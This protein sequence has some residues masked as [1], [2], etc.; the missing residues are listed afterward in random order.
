MSRRKS[1]EFQDAPAQGKLKV[2]R[3]LE[4]LDALQADETAARAQMKRDAEAERPGGFL[5]VDGLLKK[6]GKALSAPV[7]R[8]SF[9]QYSTAAAAAV[10]IEGCARRPEANIL[11]YA[12]SPE[13]LVPGVPSHFAT[14]TQRN[15]DALGIVVTSHDGR[16]TKV[17]GNPLHPSSRGASDVRAQVAVWDLYDPDR[18]HQ[19]T[20]RGDDGRT[21]KT[22]AEFDEAFGT[23]IGGLG[24]GA[25]LRVLA[26]ATNSPSMVRIRAALA[27]RF[28]AAKLYTYDSVNDDNSREGT[29]Q[30]LGQ[31]MHV[32]YELSRAR[33]V[34]SLDCDFLGLETGSVRNG[35]GF[36]PGRAITA[37][38]S[39]MSRLYVVEATH[40]ITGGSADHRLALPATRV[41]AY[42]RAL[43][44]A[45]EVPGVQAAATDGIPAEWIRAVAADLREAGRGAAVL[46]G[47]N[48]PA[49]VHALGLAINAHLGAIGST[50]LTNAVLDAE[51]P[52]SLESIRALVSEIEGANTLL[53]LGGN[54]VYDAPADVDFAAL[55][56]RDGLTSVHLAHGIDE[57]GS[58]CT[59]QVP[60]AHELETWGDLRAADGTRSIQQPLIAPLWGARSA[61]E[62]LARVAGERNWRG[63]AVVRSTFR[64]AT[65]PVSFERDW[66]AALHAGVVRGSTLT[67]ETPAID[68]SLLTA[69]LSRTAA[70][71]E[72][73]EVQFVPDAAL[74]DG[75]HAN[76]VWA[77]ELADP[78]TKIVWD[79]VALVSREFA[80]ELNVRPQDLI[81]ISKGDRSVELPVWILPGHANQSVTLTLG[82]G[83]TQAGRYAAVADHRPADKMGG[84]FRVEA[85]RDSE[86][87]Y[88]GSG[89]TVEKATG[90]Y[91]VVQT[92]THDNMEGRPIAIDA[93]LDQYK[94][95]PQFASFRTVEFVSTDPL[96]RQVNYDD[97][98]VQ[99][100][101]STLPAVLHKWGMVIDLSSCTGC[102]ACVVACQSEN[103]IPAVGK[104]EVER[105]R[106]MAWM[107]ID[108]Y[109][110]GEDSN[111]PQI[112]LQPV[113]C[114]H[115]EEAP[116]ENV[117]PVNATAHSPEGLNDMAYNRCIGTRYCANNCP[118]KVRRYNYL[119]WH[120][121][122][123][124]LIDE[125]T[126][127]SAIPGLG[128]RA[129]QD[130]ANFPEERKLAFNPN[131]TVR[132]RGVMEKC[133]YC[134]Q[135]IQGARI[136]ARR[137]QRVMRDGDIV[138][139]CQSACPT[140]AITF[141]DLNDPESRVAQLAVRDRR[142]KLLA[143][144]GT[145]PRTT[146][147]GKIRNPNPAFPAT[148][149]RDGEHA[150][151][152]GQ[153][154]HG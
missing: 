145:Q 134:V 89:F 119:D 37:P 150:A 106:E 84:G 90:H 96:W 44:A 117:C 80:N 7:S 82:Y 81:R 143:E 21:A 73:I 97:Q 123:D 66:R 39:A 92:Q 60:L 27:A 32:H 62:L 68:A 100:T 98:R 64:S 115:C 69:A 75:R 130:V 30:L 36:G 131:V 108:R 151:G 87:F 24:T 141:G 34:L 43:G 126:G 124:E 51:Q 22:Y 110:V 31:P 128:F 3:S 17:E 35:R 133:S 12:Q 152:E 105:G 29:R 135:R 109:F 140:A 118:Y 144:L 104:Y 113:G 61:L 101:D 129:G 111:N 46:V 132:M 33:T 42:A 149:G 148:G 86:S 52:R 5:A 107:R 120:V 41:D 102:N 8:R 56:G 14:V 122:L 72:G 67:A 54:P 48:Q 125:Q 63:H 154:A 6:T 93:T 19:P 9:M 10:A 121:R 95:E 76:N 26:Q 103:N 83:R 79:N 99:P 2:W 153:E 40:S 25:G 59:W 136:A 18:A 28:P 53:I 50:V 38:D 139:A 146:F 13:S 23:L 16:P 47:R 137:E 58:L 77:Q 114:Q 4:E 65:N 112:A 57:T 88:F 127:V 74:W 138:T 15:G 49:H 147:L 78:M 116:C 71:V 94:E 142:Y 55:L 45:L 70:T 85:L 91:N 1:Y 20:L 11:P